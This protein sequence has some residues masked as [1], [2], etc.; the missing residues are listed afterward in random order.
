VSGRVHD[1][2]CPLVRAVPHA[3]TGTCAYCERARMSSG[4]AALR[5]ER[6]ALRDEVE[7]LR[8]K[9]GGNWL[10]D[11]SVQ[12]VAERDALRAERDEARA[13]VDVGYLALDIAYRRHNEE[14]WA[15]ARERDSAR[16]WAGRWKALA[17]KGGAK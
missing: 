6:D 4:L 2:S 9:L 14:L 11:A 7:E 12:A 3:T 17:K 16:A 15:L 1:P 5:A 13:E 8:I 10:S